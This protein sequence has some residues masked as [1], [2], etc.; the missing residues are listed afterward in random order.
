MFGIAPTHTLNGW[1]R[2]LPS[3]A[4]FL[5]FAFIHENAPGSMFC[6]PEAFFHTIAFGVAYVVPVQ[7]PHQMNHSLQLREFMLLVSRETRVGL[8]R[9]NEDEKKYTIHLP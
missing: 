9:G 4:N 8:E 1:S 5:G 2:S 7:V 3:E 6:W